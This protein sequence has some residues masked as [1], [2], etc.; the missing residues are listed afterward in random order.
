MTDQWLEFG[1][2]YPHMMSL[3]IVSVMKNSA[4]KGIL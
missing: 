1:V 3:G 4:L 2:E